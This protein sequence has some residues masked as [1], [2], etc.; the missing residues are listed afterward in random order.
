MSMGGNRCKK[1]QLSN[2]VCEETLDE[3]V[4]NKTVNRDL[5][6][7]TGMCRAEEENDQ[8]MNLL[9]KELRGRSSEPGF[10]ADRYRH[11][12]HFRE[13]AVRDR[14]VGFRVSRRC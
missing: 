12:G 5:L 8:D 3:I 10:E 13:T 14:P 7:S 9:T 4:Q 1:Q 6:I 11:C 2:H